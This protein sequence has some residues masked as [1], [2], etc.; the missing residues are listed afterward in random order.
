[1][2]SFGIKT[3]L[4][5]FRQ[6]YR[7]LSSHFSSVCGLTPPARKR[8]QRSC[9][10]RTTTRQHGYPRVILFRVKSHRITQIP[11]IYLGC[12]NVAF[13]SRKYRR[14]IPH[15]RLALSLLS[16][17]DLFGSRQVNIL[18]ILQLP[19]RA[20]PCSTNFPKVAHQSGAPLMISGQKVVP[21]EDDATCDT[22]D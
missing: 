20:H 16:K 10:S 2:V 9:R 15:F 12:L 18:S 22:T 4:N 13:P 5:V 21:Q 17:R 8:F 1:M 14:N 7:S 3:L 19:S 6:W 11:S